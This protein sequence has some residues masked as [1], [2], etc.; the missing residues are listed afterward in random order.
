MT[1][2]QITSFLEGWF[3]CN[4]SPL[5]LFRWWWI[6]VWYCPSQLLPELPQIFSFSKQRQYEG[7]HD[8][9]IRYSGLRVVTEAHVITPCCSFCARCTG[10]MQC[11]VFVSFDRAHRCEDYWG[12]DINSKG[13]EKD[14][15][16]QTGK[17]SCTIL[18][19]QRIKLRRVRPGVRNSKALLS[20]L[21]NWCL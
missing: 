4:R 2:R 13:M 21:F 12:E 7:L 19:S 6:K 15:M 5:D 16:L 3:S 17:R 10:F 20:T 11:W 8:G 14:D 9:T 1:V 18:V